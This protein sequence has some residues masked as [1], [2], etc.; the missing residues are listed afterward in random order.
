MD[1]KPLTEEDIIAIEGAIA[2]LDPRQAEIDRRLTLAERF[3]KGFEMVEAA[4]RYNIYRLRKENPELSEAE[5]Q[6]I[7]LRRY[8][9]L[10]EMM[11]ASR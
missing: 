4:R 7:A 11:N 6:R 3:H 5:A 10:E 8:Y 2:E 1:Y 9:A